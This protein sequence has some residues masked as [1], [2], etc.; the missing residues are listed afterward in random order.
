MFKCIHC[1]EVFEDKF[2]DPNLD[3]TCKYC[4]ELD[5]FCEHKDKRG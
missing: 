1:G 2:K 4:S 5:I 3:K